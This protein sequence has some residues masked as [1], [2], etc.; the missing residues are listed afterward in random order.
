MAGYE[1]IR[2]MVD[3]LARE[4][5]ASDVLDDAFGGAGGPVYA[6]ECCALSDEGAAS[7][8]R[9]VT[10]EVE[11]LGQF[12]EVPSSTTRTLPDPGSRERSGLGIPVLG[13]AQ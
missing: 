6:D 1:Q 13:S 11:F 7:L 3:E 9:A 12:E 8:G 5:V 10:R 4:G 2:E